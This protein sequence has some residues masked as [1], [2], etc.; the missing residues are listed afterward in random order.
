MG[1]EAVKTKAS[2][3]RVASLPAFGTQLHL[4]RK[5]SLL[6][7]R[8]GKRQRRPEEQ[9]SAVLK[10]FVH[11]G[12]EAQLFDDAMGHSLLLRDMSSSE[13]VSHGHSIL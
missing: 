3:I 8:F 1:V 12:I 2:Q 5:Q 13:R 7:R 9:R 11:F 10:R 6:V 4:D